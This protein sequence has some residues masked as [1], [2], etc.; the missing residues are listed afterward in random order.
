MKR[1]VFTVICISIIATLSNCSSNSKSSLVD[2]NTKET[3]GYWYLGDDGKRQWR[4][5]T[6]DRNNQTADFSKPSPNAISPFGN[7]YER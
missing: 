7:G 4:T 1:S 3:T 2:N 5:F 6:T